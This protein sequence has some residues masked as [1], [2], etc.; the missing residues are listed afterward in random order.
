MYHQ[1]LLFLISILLLTLSSCNPDGAQ[2][3]YGTISYNMDQTPSACYVILDNDTDPNNGY[4]TRSIIDLTAMTTSV[5]YEI[6]TTN[7]S[8]GAYYLEAAWDFGTGNMDPDN[9]SVWEAKA[10]Y[11]GTSFN[12]PG[13]ANITNLNQL[14]N[15]NLAGLP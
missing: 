1:I 15:I 10:W 9:D 6:D 11:G 4:V 2:K 13:G 5:A 12:P 7:V 3:I 8:S 14:Y